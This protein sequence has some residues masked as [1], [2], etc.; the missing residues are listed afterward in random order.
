MGRPLARGE[1]LGKTR[2][3]AWGDACRNLSGDGLITLPILPDSMAKP[4][5]QD[6]QLLLT[7]MDI[8]LSDSVREA[9]KWWRTLPDGLS[10]EEFEKRFPRGSE[11]WE[12]FS[13]MAIFWETA[14]S[15]M[16]RGLLQED[17]AF[18][19]FMDAPPWGKVERIVSDRRKREKA[20]AEGENFEW[21]AGKAR[22]WVKKREAAI[23]KASGSPP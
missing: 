23:R 4:T 3:R 13:T 5:K 7:L 6:A 2:S 9:R 20:P 17:L 1:N 11:G 15:L 16:R 18:D 21:I 14:G 19:T 8:F 12:H 10:L 22:T